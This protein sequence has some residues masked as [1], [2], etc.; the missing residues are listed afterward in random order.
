MS[1]IRPYD[2][3]MSNTLRDAVTQRRLHPDGELLR[4][5]A[6]QR[7]STRCYS[8]PWDWM[9]LGDFFFVPLRGQKYSAFNV[10][11][12]QVAAR[13]DW[14]L[15]VIQVERDGEIQVRVCLTYI[16]VRAL[17]EKAQHHHGVDGIRYGD[18]QWLATRR[19][20]RESPSRPT[21][22]ARP[23]KT[24]PRLVEAPRDTS[25]GRDVGLTLLPDYD[26]DAIM[27]ARIKAL[28]PN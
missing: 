21:R 12:R 9:K 13:R 22:A 3:A 15:T 10:R 5:G 7:G 20:R 26:R 11:F 16:G 27:A 17:K 14:E 6:I 25:P 1:H 24:P 18:G 4:V 28:Q 23:T 2:I 8:Y 19:R